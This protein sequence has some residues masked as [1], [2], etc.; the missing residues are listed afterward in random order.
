MAKTLEK[1]YIKFK[2][3]FIFNE[4]FWDKIDYYKTSYP[5]KLSL[6]ET[7]IKARVYSGLRPD[8]R[9]QKINKLEW[10]RELRLSNILSLE[11]Q[12]KRGM[13]IVGNENK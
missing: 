5:Q 7:Y 13:V 2:M 11:E 8:F 4:V 12:I 3:F 9:L 10:E 6:K 1:L